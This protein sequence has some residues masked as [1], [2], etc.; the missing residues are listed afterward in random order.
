MIEINLL[1]KELQKRGGG[2]A[3]PRA[4]N[5]V[6]AGLAGLLVILGGLSY[7]QKWRIDEMQKK[8]AAAKVREAKMQHDIQLVDALTAL[9]AKI[10]ERM[11]AIE[12]LDQNRSGYVRFMEDLSGRLPEYLWLS[13]FREGQAAPAAPSQPN[14][15]GTPAAANTA[16]TSAGAKTVIEGFSYSLNSLATF[17]IQMKKSP[18]L[19]NIELS[20]AKEQKIENTRLYNFQL[21]CDLTMAPEVVPPDAEGQKPIRLGENQ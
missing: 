12:G 7:W 16:S 10:L 9:K 11:S 21:T 15:G 1:P 20:Y 17:M 14:P 18:F 13:N 5:Y 2:F 4:A 3:L 8:I 6:L 19:R